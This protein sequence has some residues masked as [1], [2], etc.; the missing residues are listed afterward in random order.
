MITTGK[1]PTGQGAL[2]LLATA[3]LCAAW[4]WPVKSAQADP[5]ASE[6]QLNHRL[7]D[8]LKTQGFTGNVE[9]TLEKRLGRRL[10]D[11][12]ANLGRLLF[13][14]PIL[15]LHGDNACAGCHSPAR[16]FGDTQ[17]IAIGVDSNR[18]VGLL[19]KGPR[20]QRRSPMLIN[21]AFYPKLMWNGR[22]AASSGDPFDFQSGF[23]FPSSEGTTRFPAG[24]PAFYHLLVAQ[25]HLPSTE[26]PEMAGFTGLAQVAGANST[27]PDFTQFDNGRGV[28]LP[29]PDETETRNEPIRTVVLA[30]LNQSPAYV[31]LFADLFPPV[32]R[33]E[34]IT[35]EMIAQAIAEFEFTLT[36]TDAPIDRFA[37]GDRRAMTTAQKRGAL[38][39]F[40]KA[41]CV[42]CHAVAGDSAE[43]FS[44]F[45]NHCIGVPQ[46][47]PRFGA[48]TGDVLFR[49]A[50]G[51]FVSEG[52]QDFGA[53]DITLDRQDRYCFRTSPL[54]NVAVQPAF[55]HN[56][57]FT[58]LED[59]IRHHLRPI[60]SA[61]RYD[62]R[63][64]G[65]AEDL[66]HNLGPIDPVLDQL[67]PLLDTPPRLTGEEFRDLVDFVRAGLLDPRA[68]PEH[69]LPLIPESLPSGEEPLEFK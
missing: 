28:A 38:L 19:R 61:R 48:G 35:F 23:E 29:L 12:L 54:R 15:A 57:A 37:R 26:L 1:S 13:F 60:A 45:E 46:V 41:A 63:A 25:A 8:V 59:A 2:R 56:G 32:A 42:Q 69:L 50:R 18:L 62:P 44:D 58:R 55:F 39:F 11:R 30:R 31:E 49:N 24:N 36:F 64:A 4:L 34:P 7:A 22:F 68:L 33:G 66:R 67:D 3:L 14:D 20:N 5:P 10:D 16:G 53:E 27:E 65:I 43:M 51:E 17:S 6:D 9:N 40:G 52:N 21:T 47:A